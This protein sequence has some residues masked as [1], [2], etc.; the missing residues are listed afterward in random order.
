[1]N[2]ALSVC[3]S[4]AEG[5]PL[6]TV[7]VTVNNMDKARGAFTA[8]TIQLGTNTAVTTTVIPNPSDG[9]VRAYTIDLTGLSAA[10]KSLLTP[11]EPGTFVVE[12]AF[13]DGGNEVSNSISLTV[14]IHQVEGL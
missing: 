11:N 3:C 4:P 14:S 8:F 7:A 1:M 2:P 10:D 5:S 9:P 13:T 6:T 12:V